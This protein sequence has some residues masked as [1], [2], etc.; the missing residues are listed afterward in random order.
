MYSNSYQPLLKTDFK[1]LDRV[2][3]HVN[4]HLFLD[5]HILLL[6]L[7]GLAVIVIFILS[8]TLDNRLYSCRLHALETG[9]VDFGLFLVCT[10][11][12]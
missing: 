10:G 12:A 5:F 2:R 4:L 3:W 9:E 1:H 11:I 6:G 8:I 7:N